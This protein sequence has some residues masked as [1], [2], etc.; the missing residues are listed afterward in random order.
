M[1]LSCLWAQ[2]KVLASW[3]ACLAVEIV[4]MVL[5]EIKCQSP[6]SQ[7]WWLADRSWW[8]SWAE[9]SPDSHTWVMNCEMRQTYKSCG[10][11]RLRQPTLSPHWSTSKTV[12]AARLKSISHPDWGNEGR[13]VRSHRDTSLNQGNWPQVIQWWT[14]DIN[15]TDHIVY[16]LK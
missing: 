9:S 16:P 10:Q 2:N 15:H 11:P 1:V 6:I 5:M 13:S 12:R 8:I 14:L 3:L 4:L 7:V